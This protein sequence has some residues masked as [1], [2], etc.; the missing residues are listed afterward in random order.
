MA[1]VEEGPSVPH[2]R[3]FF[4]LRLPQRRQQRCSPVSLIEDDQDIRNLLLRVCP[5]A[6]TAVH[7]AEDG[8]SGITSVG[9]YHPD[10]IILDYELPD[11]DGL[12][13][14]RRI[15]ETS[16]AHIFMLTAQPQIVID[17]YRTAG[18]DDLLGKPCS[19][20]NLTQRM[21]DVLATKALAHE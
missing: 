1:S 15:K 16:T 12:E 17:Q 21:N 7:L 5:W 4:I 8:L 19:V 13:G 2:R 20:R 10:V 3:A 11:I 14:A 18:I 9:E 6:G